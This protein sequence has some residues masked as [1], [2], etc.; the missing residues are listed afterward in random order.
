MR[1]TLEKFQKD[2][3]TREAKEKAL[4]NMTNEQIDVLISECGTVQGKIFYAKHKK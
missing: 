4:A 1:E 2:N 3:P